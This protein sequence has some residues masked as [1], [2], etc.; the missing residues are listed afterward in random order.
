M[1]RSVVP[2]A[3]AASLTERRTWALRLGGEI[4]DHH[5]RVAT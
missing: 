1:E 2:P 3:S 4:G 5:V